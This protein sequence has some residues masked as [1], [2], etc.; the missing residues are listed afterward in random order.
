MEGAWL[1]TLACTIYM[2]H[3]LGLGRS[4][5]ICAMLLQGNVKKCFLLSLS[6]ANTKMNR[7][8]PSSDSCAQVTCMAGP[9]SNLG[10]APHR[11]LCLISDSNEGFPEDLGDFSRS[12]L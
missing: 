1:R 11:R 7:V 6:S 4:A 9:A 12:F 2:G 10:P 3:R 5:S 8:Q